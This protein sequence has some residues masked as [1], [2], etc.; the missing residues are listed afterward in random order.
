MKKYFCK[1]SIFRYLLN[2]IKVVK[3]WKFRNKKLNY[4]PKM[5][6]IETTN[7][8]NFKCAF[9]PQ[10]ASDYFDACPKGEIDISQVEKIL[11]IMRREGAWSSVISFTLGGEPFMHSKFEE[12]I[13]LANDYGFHPEFAS[14]FSL[15]TPERI[16]NLCSAGYFQISVDFS[17]NEDF[18][19][20]YRG[21]PGSWKNV[22]SNLRYLLQ[23]TNKYPQAHVHISDITNWGN[24]G[25][26][27]H[28]KDLLSLKQLFSDINYN[29]NHVVFKT[30]LFHNFTGFVPVKRKKSKYHLCPY[31]WLSVRIRWNGDC[32]ICCRDI[33][34][35]TVLGNVFKDES[36]LKVWESA[37]YQEARRLLAEKKPDLLAA[38]GAC[39]LPWGQDD[40]RWNLSYLLSSYLKK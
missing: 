16:D 37:A 40:D 18:F 20:K 9:C 25:R 11:K 31:A 8:C 3:A 39:D 14:N 15:A 12:I 1:V 6:A 30:R 4:F 38:C 26:K 34:S 21:F 33:T 28:L 35:R 24:D 36:I 32:V 19:E 10:S 13:G 5:V 23:L 7:K 22:L 29:K 17:H 27:P 2:T